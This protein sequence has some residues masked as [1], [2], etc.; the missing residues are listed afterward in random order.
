LFAGAPASFNLQP[1]PSFPLSAFCFGLS[2]A[3]SALVYAGHQPF[4]I[5]CLIVN[6]EA[7]QRVPVFDIQEA[8][9]PVVRRKTRHALRTTPYEKMTFSNPVNSGHEKS[10]KVTFGHPKS[11]PHPNPV[12]ETGK[13]TVKF[14]TAA[15]RKF[16][17]FSL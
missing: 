15:S 2:L 7:G 1:A 11:V 3:A 14:S 10:R 4:M 9:K 17:K 16:P 13:E 5:H 6:H 12:K 8:D